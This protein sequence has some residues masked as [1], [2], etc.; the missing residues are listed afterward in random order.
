MDGGYVTLALGIIGFG[1]WCIKLYVDN[2][3]LIGDNERLK[4]KIIELK[5]YIKDSK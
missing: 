2:R 1:A 4:E 5:E 3:A